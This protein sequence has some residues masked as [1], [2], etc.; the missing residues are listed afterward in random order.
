VSKIPKNLNIFQGIGMVI[1]TLLGSGIFIVPSLTASLSGTNSLLGWLI[2]SCLIIPIA[3]IF[4]VLGSRYP[5]LE[6]SA[7]FVKNAFGEKIGS[8]V[9]CVNTF[10]PELGSLYKISINGKEEYKIEF[11]TISIEKLQQKRVNNI[12]KN[13]CFSKELNS[14][15]I[16]NKY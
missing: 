12:F 5:H 1:M 13:G 9:G 16:A 14:A 8:I 11:D 15:I 2:L 6:G 10:E 4:G 3:Y 7:F